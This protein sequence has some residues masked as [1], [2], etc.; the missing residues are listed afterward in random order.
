M[1]CVSK[2]GLA[3]FCSVAV[4]SVGLAQ[5]APGGSPAAAAV[6]LRQS[7][8]DVQ[9]FA[10]APMTVFLKGGPFDAAAAVTAAERIQLTSA[11]IPEVFKFDTRNAKVTTRARD[12]IWTSMADFIQKAHDLQNA[13]ANL[14]T[15]A[16]TGDPDMTK[17]AAIAVGKACGSCH[18]EFRND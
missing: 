12:G 6:K 1:N 7:L 17:Q 3:A 14:E 10:F 4:V 9:N 15:A 13:A 11:M 8:F 18:D 5:S 16:K 2:L